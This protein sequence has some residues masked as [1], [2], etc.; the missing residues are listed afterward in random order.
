MKNE[1][2]IKR[3]YIAG[4]EVC[5]PDAEEI[6]RRKKALCAD[7]GFI[8]LFPDDIKVDCGR[9]GEMAYNIYRGH[10][11]MIHSAHIGICNLTPFRGESAD[12][13]TAFA[14]GMLVGLQKQVFGYS[15]MVEDFK[16]SPPKDESRVYSSTEDLEPFR[17]IDSCLWF[18]GH[19]ILQRKV[20]WDQLFQSLSGFEACLREAR[21]EE[22]KQ[23][24]VV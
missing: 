6:G 7:Y 11:E 16:G 17:L 1:E 13:D 2:E 10:V 20:A 23:A 18:Q 3:V 8:G 4:P 21:A 22:D 19:L 14:L 5:L 15:H 24:G 12:T 9:L